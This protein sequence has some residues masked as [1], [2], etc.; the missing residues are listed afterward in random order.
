[1]GKI[2]NGLKLSCPS[3]GRTQEGLV[4]LSDKCPWSYDVDL[5]A[6]SDSHHCTI[7]LGQRKALGLLLRMLLV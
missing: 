6:I 5:A 4:V 1:M 7:A 2:Y 3:R